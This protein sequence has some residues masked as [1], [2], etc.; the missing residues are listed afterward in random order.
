[1]INLKM[2]RYD[3][4]ELECKTARTNRN[5]GVTINIDFDIDCE[6]I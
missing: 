1:L 5:K 6:G 4:Y 3:N 2:K